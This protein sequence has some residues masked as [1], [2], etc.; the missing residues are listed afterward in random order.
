MPTSIPVTGMP[1][2]AR[3]SAVGALGRVADVRT[4]SAGSVEAGPDGD[5]AGA[6]P[7]E[8]L[9]ARV[10]RMMSNPPGAYAHL[11]GWGMRAKRGAL[12]RPTDLARLQL[13]AQRYL[14][15]D[16]DIIEASVTAQNKP[17]GATNTI[18]FQVV[19]RTR[20]GLT[21]SFLTTLGG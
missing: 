2:F 18:L 3:P 10:D 19:I 1:L 20:A 17:K 16:P 9:R 8:A 13:Q 5:L 12:A 15:E 14:T 6:T 4:T 7:V 21:D 11:R